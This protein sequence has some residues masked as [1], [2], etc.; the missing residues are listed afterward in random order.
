MAERKKRIKLEGKEDFRNINYEEKEEKLLKI[1]IGCGKNKQ[2]DHIGLDRLK[3]PGVDHVLDL[4][5]EKLPFKDNSVDE[6]YTSHFIE[7]LDAVERCH[8]LNEIHRVLKTGCKCTLIVPYWASSRAY[9]DPT[10]K[11][12]PIGEMWFFYLNKK[13]R[14]ENAPHTDK[15]HWAQGY[16]CDFDMTWGYTLHQNMMSR[17]QEYVQHALTFW[18]EAGQDI[19]ATLTK[20]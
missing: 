9:G 19:Q 8:M 17:N 15:E 13:W 18:K 1:D 20:K 10:H 6:V 2:P 4:A 11:W 14:D 5:K 12:P 3:F 7:H 16:G